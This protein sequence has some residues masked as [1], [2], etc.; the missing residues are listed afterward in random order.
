GSLRTDQSSFPNSLPPDIAPRTLPA[1]PPGF[2]RLSTN[3]SLDTRYGSSENV[4]LRRLWQ[5][6]RKR[7]WM[8]L[9]ITLV[10][11]TLVTIDA[12]R[13]KRLYQATATIEIGREGGTIVAS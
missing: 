13:D 10:A 9:A 6:V 8:V 4:K 2:P 12:Y 7:L 3:T 5:I 1:M 11:A